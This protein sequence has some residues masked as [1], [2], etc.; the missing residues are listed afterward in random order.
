MG[1]ILYKYHGEDQQKYDKEKK[2]MDKDYENAL[3]GT[4]LSIL[5]LS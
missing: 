2:I 3:F 4:Q 1:S 5:T